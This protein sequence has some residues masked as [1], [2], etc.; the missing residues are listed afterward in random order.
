MCYFTPSEPLSDEKAQ[1]IIDKALKSSSLQMRNV[2]AVIT[3]LM[4]SEKTW[5]LSRLFNQQPP[6]LYTNTGIAEQS[7]QG[8]LH[9]IMS[10]SSWEMFSHENLLK[11]LFQKEMPPAEVVKVDTTLASNESSELATTDQLLLPTLPS[12][13]SSASSSAPTPMKAS[14]PKPKPPLQITRSVHS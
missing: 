5:L 9:H 8:L 3:G 11:L 14:A 12:V 2:V 4:G 1:E 10:L 7:V 6:D 13:S